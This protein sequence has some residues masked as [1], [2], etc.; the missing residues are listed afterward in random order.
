MTGTG[1]VSNTLRKKNRRGVVGGGEEVGGKAA[2]DVRPDL[3]EE[4][5]P[6]KFVW[7]DLPK[8]ELP[9]ENDSL[10]V[11]RSAP[12]TC[13]VRK[14]KKIVEQFTTREEVF[15]LQGQEQKRALDVQRR[16]IEKV[17]LA[18]QA[19]HTK[20]G[21]DDQRLQSAIRDAR[22]TALKVHEYNT[23]SANLFAG[24][25]DYMRNQKSTS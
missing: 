19:H 3:M 18:K 21:K 2:A 9:V 6:K 22:T 10:Y 13:L 5:A 25:D 16:S 7:K 14:T 4:E 1:R 23:Y 20:K 11:R 8:V 24:H 17:L 12:G 15:D